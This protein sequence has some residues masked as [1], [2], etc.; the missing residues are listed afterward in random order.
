MNT[1]P[2]RVQPSQLRP[3]PTT[4]SCSELNVILR[5][6]LGQGE[7]KVLETKGVLGWSGEL[8]RERFTFVIEDKGCSGAS[9]NHTVWWR[10]VFERNEN[11]QLLWA[12]FRAS[13]QYIGGVQG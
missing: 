12:W 8:M 10:A 9:M 11:R 3:Q 13:V 1:A 5:Y 7:A 6:I 4:E 2:I